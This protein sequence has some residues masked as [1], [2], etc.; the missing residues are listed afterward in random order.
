MSVKK[1]SGHAAGYPG[2][3]IKSS[4]DR[5]LNQTPKQPLFL[6]FWRE[7]AIAKPYRRN[8]DEP[9][10]AFAV[11][12]MRLRPSSSETLNSFNDERMFHVLP[13]FAFS[14][15]VASTSGGRPALRRQSRRER[16][17]LS[18]S[19]SHPSAEVLIEPESIAPRMFS[20]H[21]LKYSADSAASRGSALMGHRSVRFQLERR[22][23]WPPSLCSGLNSQ[24]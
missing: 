2:G 23:H 7:P 4:A 15:L 21:R 18:S 8:D 6:L 1:W 13:S 24:R 10:A 22:H 12:G 19:S 16:A 3:A 17:G 11:Y 9:I 5:R 20:T 14:V